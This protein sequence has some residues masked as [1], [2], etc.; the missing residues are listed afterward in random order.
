[1]ATEKRQQPEKKQ[2]YNIKV[3]VHHSKPVLTLLQSE[4]EKLHQALANAAT[5]DTSIWYRERIQ[6]IH[7]SLTAP[8]AKEI[9]RIFERETM[10]DENTPVPID[11]E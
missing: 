11:E 9:R 2:V 10:D 1:M 3:A 7:K 8:D 4:L 5:P 6:D